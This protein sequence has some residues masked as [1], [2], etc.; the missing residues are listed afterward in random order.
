M[1]GKQKT[2]AGDKFASEASAK[3]A[4][5]F[6]AHYFPS[7]SHC[8]QTMAGIAYAICG[9]LK[10]LFSVA[11]ASSS[12]TTSANRRTQISTRI[13]SAVSPIVSSIISG[14]PFVNNLSPKA[15]S[16]M[17]SSIT[18]SIENLITDT[19]QNSCELED[20]DVLESVIQSLALLCA[21]GDV[22]GDANTKKLSTMITHHFKAEGLSLADIGDC[23]MFY[24]TQSSTGAFSEHLF[25]IKFKCPVTWWPQRKAHA[26]L[27][28]TGARRP[29]MMSGLEDANFSVGS[30]DVM[31]IVGRV[32]RHW[33]SSCASVHSMTGVD[34]LTLTTATAAT[35]STSHRKE[36]IS[37][38]RIMVPAKML[39]D[40]FACLTTM[41]NSVR[42]IVMSCASRDVISV[43]ETM[44]DEAMLAVLKRM[45][46]AAAARFPEDCAQRKV[47]ERPA[48][49]MTAAVK[50]SLF[51]EAG[52]FLPMAYQ[53]FLY[54]QDAIVQPA[55]AC[56]TLLTPLL[57]KHIKAVYES[58]NESFDEL[59][60]EMVAMREE[61]A[62]MRASMVS[63]TLQQQHA[64]QSQRD[65]GFAPLP[66]QLQQPGLQ[67]MRP[68]RAGG[69]TGV[70]HAPYT[71]E[72]NSSS[73]S[74][75]QGDATNSGQQK[76][77]HQ[78]P[79]RKQDVLYSQGN[80]MF[81]M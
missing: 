20:A 25:P 77:H 4:T 21:S 29:E 46:E 52:L 49:L 67:I 15:A 26:A 68:D 62:G 79:P 75:R 23:V 5:A 18:S 8:R 14:K 24:A 78:P 39:T 34:V 81:E 19:S 33:H 73:S 64:L 3:N 32:V 27:E 1:N 51:A 74:F 37:Q 76:Y 66:A 41:L 43:E 36:G 60:K 63:N 50:I 13:M 70:S 31:T 65:N 59:V 56:K 54:N 10:T 6:S 47:L 71:S 40:S 45:Q 38:T 58:K 35:S 11:R 53:N 55:V 44:N 42:T 22:D 48:H 12:C 17:S 57:N 72:R 28:Y 69:T 2:T 9:I 30:I 7:Q 80:D 61:M 16:D